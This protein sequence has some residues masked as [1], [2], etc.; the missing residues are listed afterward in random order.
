[1]PIFTSFLKLSSGNICDFEPKESEKL[2][3]L[4]C[5]HNTP[6]PLGEGR[7]RTRPTAAPAKILVTLPPRRINRLATPA[8]IGRTESYQKDAASKNSFIALSRSS[9]ALS[10]AASATQ[11]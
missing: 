8:G 4:D 2:L 7:V 10:P 6:L 11:A 5:A 3:S 1:M 9:V